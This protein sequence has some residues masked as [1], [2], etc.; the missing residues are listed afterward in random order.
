[1]VPDGHGRESIGQRPAVPAPLTTVKVSS[2]DEQR[3]MPVAEAAERVVD[4]IAQG[5]LALVPFGVAYAF[6]TGSREP[7]AR[8]YELKLRPPKKTCPILVSWEDFDDIAEATPSQMDRIRRVIEADLPVGVLVKPRWDSETARSIPKDCLELLTTNGKLGLFMNMGGMSRHLL[9]AGA[10][11]GVR[12]FGSSANISGMGNSFSLEEV[13]EGIVSK[14][15]IVC[16]AGTCTHAN[17]DR[18]PSSI[19]DLETGRLTRRGILHHEIER[20][21]DG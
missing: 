2:G 19:V 6:L 21:L 3:I 17:P 4:I 13:P 14:M 5:G 9:E 11:A 8:I 10:R 1:M 15:D 16:E 12:L 7:L 18:L 20:L